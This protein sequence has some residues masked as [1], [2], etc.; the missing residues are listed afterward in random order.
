MALTFEISNTT[1]VLALDAAMDQA[2]AGAGAA[3]IQIRTG[4]QPAD[5]ETANSGTLLASLTM[6]DPAFGGATDQAPGARATASAIA[7]DTSA[8]ADG[9]AGHF[10]IF[11]STLT[12]CHFQG[13]C[14]V[15]GA[16]LNFDDIIFVEGGTV[17]ISALT[18]DMPES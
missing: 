16:D 10:R 15:S 5:C 18:V 6:S 1:A 14:A 13:S 12:N 8:D 4:A 2:D 9:T 7:S 17:A 3:I 11:E